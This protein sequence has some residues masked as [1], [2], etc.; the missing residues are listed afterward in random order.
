MYVVMKL[1]Y[2]KTLQAAK[3]QA[4]ANVRI[5]DSLDKIVS[6]LEKRNTDL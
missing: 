2:G 3:E 4:D 1:I 5:A 6:I